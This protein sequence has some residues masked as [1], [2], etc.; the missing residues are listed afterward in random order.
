MPHLSSK[1]FMRKPCRDDPVFNYTFTLFNKIIED[2]NLTPE[3][4]KNA[5]ASFHW[6]FTNVSPYSRGSSWTGEIL[7]DILWLMHGYVPTPIEKGK[8][9][10]L[11]AMGNTL[12][13]YQEQYPMGRKIH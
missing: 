9:L 11:E 4:L 10:D 3:E 8:S 13:D 12:K 6:H 5:I 7:S 2:I 1:I